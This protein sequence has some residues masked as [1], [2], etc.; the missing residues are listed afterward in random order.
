[1]LHWLMYHCQVPT[2]CLTCCSLQ[3]QAAQSVY[4]KQPSLVAYKPKTLKRNLPY[5]RHVAENGLKTE[6]AASIIA[7]ACGKLAGGGSTNTQQKSFSEWGDLPS[8]S[9]GGSSN[10]SS[11]SSGSS[12][13]SSLSQA[14]G[15]PD[16][17]ADSMSDGTTPAL[18][19]TSDAVL[20]HLIASDPKLLTRSPRGLA[21]KVSVLGKLVGGDDDVGCELLIRKPSLA[22]KSISSLIG[23]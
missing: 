17:S 21:R 6:Y 18:A 7:A 8:S 4:L 10:N 15:H 23:E 5:L 3:R 2:P 20:Q 11:S 19:S 22:R 16:E 14:A 9:S 12:S 1:M 13:S